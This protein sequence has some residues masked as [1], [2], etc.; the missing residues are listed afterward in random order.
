[1]EQRIEFAEYDVSD[2]GRVLN[3]GRLPIP[4]G[5]TLTWM[6]HVEVGGLCKLN[7]VHP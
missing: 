6:G 3:R 1:M 7:S 5:H 4:P 2:G